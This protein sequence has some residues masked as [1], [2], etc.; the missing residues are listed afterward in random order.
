MNPLVSLPERNLNI[1]RTLAVGYVLV[2]HTVLTFR[3]ANVWR[4]IGFMGVCLFFVHTSLVL[5]GSIDRMVREFNKDD[6][7]QAGT[8][9]RIVM[10]FYIRRALRIYPL[11]VVTIL[12]CL[13]LQIPFSTLLANAGDPQAPHRTWQ[14]IVA[15][16]LLV[17]NLFGAN[18]VTGVLW[19]L[20]L[21]VQMYL[22]LPFAYLLVRAGGRYVVAGLAAA[23]AGGLVLYLF[24]TDIRFIWRL[25]VLSYA[26][27]FMS[28]VLAYYLL[29]VKRW[30]QLPAWTWPLVVLAWGAFCMVVLGFNHS[31]IER[32]SWPFCIG[33][34]CLI[35]LVR[36]MKDSALTRGADSVARYSYGVY[37]LH[38]PV[39]AI[40][41][42]WLKAPTMLVN[43]LV[44]GFLICA[45]PVLAFRFIEDPFVRLGRKWTSGNAS[46]PRLAN[47]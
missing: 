46:R 32:S 16:L 8:R 26:P 34:G 6:L 11:S 28:G 20:P 17:Q 45:L 5:M 22:F 35:P 4:N 47:Q 33:I 3:E 30:K 1:L 44:Y 9:F 23:I 21:E 24:K 7:N 12:A 38:L 40:S 10:S 19:S 14:V 18:D 31:T 42:L 39:I 13:V 25:S 15:N 27:C 41:F 43:W 29:K 2:D 36:N 37:L